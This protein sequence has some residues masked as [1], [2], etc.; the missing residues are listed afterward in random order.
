MDDPNSAILYSIYVD[1]VEPGTATNQTYPLYTGTDA[2]QHVYLGS[3]GGDSINLRVMVSDEFG[4]TI[5]GG[6]RYM[7]FNLHSKV[8]F[9]S[10]P[11][12]MNSSNF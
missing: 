5:L 1:L 12:D 11:C 10:N 8:N 9:F 6:H 2:T 3:Y 4:A 7:D